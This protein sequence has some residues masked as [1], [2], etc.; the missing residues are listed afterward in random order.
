MTVTLS[1]FP[2]CGSTLFDY[3]RFVVFEPGYREDAFLDTL[4]N[5]EAPFGLS[6]ISG[7]IGDYCG[8]TFIED[9]DIIEK[10]VQVQR[11]IA[12]WMAVINAFSPYRST[13]AGDGKPF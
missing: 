8:L 5:R 3:P 1:Y 13:E 2:E 12:P 6:Y 10:W 11:E 7:S 4:R 9:I